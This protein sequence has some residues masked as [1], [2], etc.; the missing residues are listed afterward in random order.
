MFYRKLYLGTNYRLINKHFS[1]LP[2]YNPLSALIKMLKN[3]L[4]NAVFTK[5]TE[6]S[7]IIK[8][9]EVL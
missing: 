7:Q 4:S 9:I 8:K 3:I 5:T 1:I 6:Q 2:K